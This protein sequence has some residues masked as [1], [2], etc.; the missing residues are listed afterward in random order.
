MQWRQCFWSKCGMGKQILHTC[1]SSVIGIATCCGGV[2]LLERASDCSLLHTLRLLRA[3]INL[4]ISDPVRQSPL[5]IKYCAFLLARKV[6]VQFMGCS[7][8]C[9]DTAWINYKNIFL[10]LLCVPNTLIKTTV[11]NKYLFVLDKY[12]LRTVVLIKVLVIHARQD[13]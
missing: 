11:R 8:G 7:H 1:T 12:L 2:Y 5:V 3:V 4:L 9:F 13:A 10:K 6:L